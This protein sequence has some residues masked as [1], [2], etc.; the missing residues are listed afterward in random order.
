MLEGGPVYD[1]VWWHN[2]LFHGP[3][4]DHVVIHFQHLA[5]WDTRFGR[6]EPVVD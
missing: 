1:N 6:L 3:A 4:E 5:S 2:T